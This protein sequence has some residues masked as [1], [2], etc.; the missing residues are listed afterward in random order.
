MKKLSEKLHS[1]TGASMVIALVFM[2]ICTFIGGVVLAASTVN[3]NRVKV[4][5]EQQQDFLN[6][7]S[8]AGVLVDDL[9]APRNS[10]NRL[11]IS[12]MVNTY[13]PVKI[14]NGGAVVF[15]Y[16]AG[17]TDVTEKKVRF[18]VDDKN[19]LNRSALREIMFESAALRFFALAHA[20]A[21]PENDLLLSDAELEGFPYSTVD[22][23]MVS[24]TDSYELEPVPIQIENPVGDDVFDAELV[25]KETDG[26]YSF[27]VT[28]GDSAQLNLNMY[29][30]VSSKPVQEIKSSTPVEMSGGQFDGGLY[31]RTVKTYTTV[32]DWQNP[33]VIKGGA[34]K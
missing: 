25:C 5:S 30:R 3:S 21:D 34:G 27:A 18:S 22:K 26:Q 1:R 24:L 13:N 7:R 23:F 14:D 11:T 32:I 10:K 4:L 20:D 2:L 31:R 8:L 15:D 28:F 33:E 17:R 16:A 12:F 6:Q 29:A 9:S 19:V